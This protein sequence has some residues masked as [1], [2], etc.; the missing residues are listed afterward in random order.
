MR[1][2]MLAA[3]ALQG[4]ERDRNIEEHLR[5]TFMRVYVRFNTWCDAFDR[6]LQELI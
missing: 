2:A 1:K 6:H 4:L 3:K 5:I